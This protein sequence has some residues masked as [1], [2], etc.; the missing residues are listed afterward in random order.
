MELNLRSANVVSKSGL[1][2]NLGVILDNKLSFISHIDG[3]I[4][5]SLQMPGFIKRCC[6]DFRNADDIRTLY[7]ALAGLHLE[8]TASD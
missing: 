8:Y 4:L 7:L 3:I 2:I 5:K 6:K 1:Q